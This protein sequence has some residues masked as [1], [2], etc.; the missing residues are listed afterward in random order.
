MR[1]L[2]HTSPHHALLTSSDHNWEGAKINRDII[3]KEDRA[4]S[5][6]AP[7]ADLTCEFVLVQL[8]DLV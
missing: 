1:V 7:T 8:S 6:T 4:L 5:R 3:F 2:N